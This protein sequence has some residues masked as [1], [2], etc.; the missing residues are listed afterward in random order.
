MTKAMKHLA[1]MI[2]LAITL[3]LPTLQLPLQIAANALSWN[4]SSRATGTRSSR[5]SAATLSP[6]TP[7][8]PTASSSSDRMS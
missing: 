1:V 5:T 7:S 6:T 3:G 4:K 8:P 2:D